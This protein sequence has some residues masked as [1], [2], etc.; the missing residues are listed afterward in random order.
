MKVSLFFIYLSNFFI[1]HSDDLITVRQRTASV[2][3]RTVGDR[4]QG[5]RLYWLTSMSNCLIL[6]CKLR[7]PNWIC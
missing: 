3:Q 7:R 5:R 1:G 4:I 2:R 6:R